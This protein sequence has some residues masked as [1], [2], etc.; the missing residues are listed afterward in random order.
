MDDVQNMHVKKSYSINNFLDFQN[1]LILYSPQ[2]Q[3]KLRCTGPYTSSNLFDMGHTG[4]PWWSTNRYTQH[5]IEYYWFL[6]HVEYT[7]NLILLI[8]KK[9]AEYG[10]DIPTSFVMTIN[11]G[12]DGLVFITLIWIGCVCVFINV[13]ICAG[14]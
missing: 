9:H 1:W 13:S 14:V 3:G 12:T 7:L 5:F 8:I 11:L 10:G 6:H 4:N 2:N